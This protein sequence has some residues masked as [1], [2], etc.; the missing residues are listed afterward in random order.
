MNISSAVIK[1]RPEHIEAVKTAL[2][3]SG[4]CEIHFS[5]DLGRIVVSIEGDDN[6]DESAKLKKIAALPNIATADF[7][8]TYRDDDTLEAESGTS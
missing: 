8:Y 4:L 6:A 1:T 2:A 5:D 7:A 3:A